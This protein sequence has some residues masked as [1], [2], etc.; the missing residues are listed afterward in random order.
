MN[1]LSTHKKRYLYLDSIK[2]IT[3][4]LVVWMHCI[5][6]VM[7]H[8]PDNFLYSKVYAF[9]M[10]VFMIISGMLFEKKIGGGILLTMNKQLFRLIVPNIFWGVVML[11][12]CGGVFTDVIKLPF[13][14]WFLSSLF[15][16]SILY[17]LFYRIVK[18]YFILTI[19]VSLTL[20]LCHVSEFVTFFA[21][22]FG[23]GMIIKKIDFIDKGD[24]FF[25]GLAVI[26]CLMI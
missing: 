3:I 14:C 12:F 7:G 26:S 23:I 8:G 17:L 9:H 18:N 21:P 16:C 19:V 6:N 24:K 15:I 11:F 2:G 4:F 13:T 10:P 20:L 25:Y 22:F 5:Q 1:E